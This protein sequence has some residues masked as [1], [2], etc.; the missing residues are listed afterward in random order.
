MHHQA[1]LWLE[2]CVW[3]T[4]WQT[5]RPKQNNPTV[6]SPQNIMSFL[7]RLINVFFG[8]YLSFH[9]GTLWGLLA[10]TSSDCNR[11][12]G[13]LRSSWILELIVDQAF[14]SLLVS[15]FFV[16]LVLA[17]L[18][19]F[20]LLLSISWLKNSPSQVSWTTHFT[21]FFKNQHSQ[22]QLPWSSN[23]DLFF[24]FFV[25]INTLPI[26]FLFPGCMVQG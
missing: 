1:S 23:N 18:C 11:T 17:A 20:S 24:F 26:F 10:G 16:F 5:L 7:F 3:Q 13:S 25:R 19:R 22:C 2:S 4:V 9:S 21:C 12:H 15:F 14:A 6:I 8:K